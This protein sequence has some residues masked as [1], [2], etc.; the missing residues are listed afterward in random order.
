[1]YNYKVSVLVPVYNVAGFLEKCLDS[2]LAQTYKDFELIL[3]DDGSMDASGSICDN[4]AKAD[5]RV[6]VYHRI[7]HGIS[8]TRQFALSQAQGEYIM[9]VDSDD[10]IASDMIEQMVKSADENKSDIVG[11]NLKVIWD[12]NTWDVIFSYDTDDAFIRDVIASNWA[13]LWR[14]LFR[15]SLIDDNHIAF[16]ANINNGEDY[17]FVVSCVL[18]A[19]R[20]SHVPR[21]LYYYNRLNPFSTIATVNEEKT[22]EQIDAT[23][24][25]EKMLRTKGLNKVYKGEIMFRKHIAKEQL[26]SISFWK[27]MKAFPEANMIQIRAWIGMLLRK[28][29]VHFKSNLD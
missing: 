29:I 14:M 9:W 13:V 4:Y 22:Y 16:P 5:K 8:Q 19:K 15:H 23:R 18:S 28:Y 27:W 25:V 12:K 10:W 1:M 2:V 11:C 20:Y 24:I 3:V 17:V 7:N 26:L 21:I 6:K